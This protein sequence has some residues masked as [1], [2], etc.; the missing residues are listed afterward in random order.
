MNSKKKYFWLI[1]PMLLDFTTSTLSYFALT[2]VN[3]SIQQM[4]NGATPVFTAFFALCIL[5]QRLYGFN[6]IAVL[7]VLIGMVLVG[8][9][10][11]LFLD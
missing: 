9:S 1:F 7:F 8:L 4:F 6:W 5:K 3:A 10:S 2:I 11:F